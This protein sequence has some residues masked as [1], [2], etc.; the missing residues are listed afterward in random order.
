VL[1]RLAAGRARLLAEMF[2]GMPTDAADRAA[3][4]VAAEVAAGVGA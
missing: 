4:A 1:D 2:D 3:A